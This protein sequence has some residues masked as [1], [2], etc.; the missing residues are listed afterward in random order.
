[1][2]EITAIWAVDDGTKIKASDL[3]SS[4]R[5]GNEIFQS[6]TPVVRIFGSRN[7]IVSFQVILEGGKTATTQVRVSLDSVGSIKN[8]NVSNNPDT[9]FLGRH[10]EI[11]KEHYL[12]I[13]TRSQ[14]LVWEPWTE[15]Q[16]KGMEGPVPDALIPLRENETFSVGRRRNQGIW[17]DIYI[18]KD[19]PAGLHK[20]V[21]SIDV[22]GSPC[23]LPACQLSIELDVLDVSLPD[24]PTIKTMLWFSGSD[25]DRDLMAARY[26][27]NPWEASQQAVEALRQRHFKLSRRHRITLFLGSDKNPNESLKDRMSG[28]I[29][30]ASAGYEGPGQGVKQDMYSIHTYGGKLTKTEPAIWADWFTKYAPHAEYFLYV[31]DEPNSNDF[32]EVNLRAK[33]A[34]PVPA[35]TTHQY[36]PEVHVDIY[37]AASDTYSVKTAAR[38]AAKNKRVWIYNGVRPFTGTFI[39]DDVA[40]SPRVNPWIQYKYKIPRW[41][42]WESTYY[43]DNQGD[44][45]NINVFQQA[46]NF[47]N[48]DGDK[49]NGDGLL[50]YP[51]R[52]F[53]FPE[54]DRGIDGPL[55][56][57]RLKNWR[58]GIQ[59]VEYLRLAEAA[60]HKTYV[61]ALLKT[62]IPKALADETR[63]GDPVSW[64]ENGEK[65]IRARRKLF[66]LL[67]KGIPPVLQTTDIGKEKES[68]WQKYIRELKRIKRKWMQGKR[69]LLVVAGGAGFGLLF[70]VL[71]LRRRKK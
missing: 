8:Q 13:S 4:L 68:N 26:Y 57:I 49:L 69:R 14:A 12:N 43:K 53:I 6:E 59:D 24:T 7:E 16:P 47:R 70:V 27:K 5:H 60:G 36:H 29:F 32:P 31:W 10:I 1:M 44:R 42:Y 23:P 40:I 52:D 65:W 17:V 30:T 34:K 67:R 20:G 15:A 18:P 19:A 63:A 50:F 58:R 64:P 39:I 41:F 55:P 54:E 45:G 71:F 9:Y 62:M 37:A 11:F 46:Q 48:S 22:A 28:K 56:S 66:L 38:A 21:M 33:Q 61:E 3:G 2:A 51:G 25:N 35:F